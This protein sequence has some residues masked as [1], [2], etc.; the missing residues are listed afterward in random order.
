MYIYIYIYIYIYVCVYM[1]TYTR[2]NF[3]AK[4]YVCIHQAEIKPWL[5]GV[6]L[7]SG[8]TA[9]WLGGDASAVAVPNR[10]K[11]S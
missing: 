1:Y 8:G 4:K 9:S 6:C 10:D 3:A 2:R 7:F 5:T 11:S